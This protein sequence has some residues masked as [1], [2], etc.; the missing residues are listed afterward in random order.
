MREKLGDVTA[1]NRSRVRHVTSLAAWAWTDV[2]N[3]ANNYGI[4]RKVLKERRERYYV[5]KMA[6][7]L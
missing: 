1:A 3:D 7:P 6:S 5:N 2:S 4:S